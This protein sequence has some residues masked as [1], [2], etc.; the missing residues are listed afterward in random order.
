M[1]RAQPALRTRVIFAVLDLLSA[2][3]VL[4]TMKVLWSA[5]ALW[6]M[7]LG[8]WA[9]SLLASAIGLLT[10]TRTGRFF[11]RLAAVYQLGFLLVL[12]VGILSSVAYLSGI[13]GQVGVGVA[14]VLLLILALLLELMGLVPIFKLR[15]IGVLENDRPRLHRAWPF[16]ALALVVGVAF[17]CVSVHASAS[18]GPWVPISNDG[19]EA[20]ARYLSAI[21]IGEAGPSPTTNEG[22]PRD[23]WV[24]RAYRRGRLVSRIE[25]QGSLDEA[26]EALGEALT[27]GG[28]EAPSGRCSIA[29]DRIVAET[30]IEDRTGLL[31]ALSIVPGMDGVTGDIDGRRFAIAP[32]EL[33]LRRMLSEHVPIAFIPDF[34][35]GVDLDEARELLCA[36][37][38]RAEDCRVEALRRARTESWVH[39]HENTYELQRGRP[40][41]DA[42]PS[43][44]DARR[45][46][47]SAGTYVVRALQTDGRFRYKLFPESARSEMDPYSIAR[48]AGTTWFLLELYEATGSLSHLGSAQRALDWLEKQLVDCGDGL[49]CLRQG[50]RARLGTQALS[51]I[52]FST[53]SRVASSDRYA[54]TIDDLAEVILRLQRDDGDFDFALDCELGR[55]IAGDRAFYAAGQAAL[56][57]A[58][59]GQVD[60]DE[61]RLHGARAALDFMAG[62]YWDFFLSDLFFLEE[63]WTC[64]AADEVHR[65]YGDPDHAHL[66]LAVAGFNRQLQHHRGETVFE[67]YVGGVGFTPFFPPYTTSTATRADAMI[68]AY[69]ISKRQG[70][71]DPALRQGIIDAV[72]FLTHNQYGREDT[73][74]FRSGSLA[75]GGVPW[76]YYDP[77]I[78]I[79][80]VQHCG[81]V[82]LHGADVIADARTLDSGEE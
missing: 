14:V 51:L 54:N 9:A 81:A 43:A 42:T 78:R 44:E 32:Q 18:L 22:T 36:N 29:I 17:H 79:D 52:A 72:A 71:P 70:E 12:T 41:L 50:N 26:A 31:G 30:D 53:H 24:V 5:S 6:P 38:K 16:A 2:A 23:H 76:S 34:E 80:T 60:D 13:Y 55:T 46:A 48:H 77:V 3:A 67:D 15:S 49:R 58:L 35:I 33:V 56:A 69:R 73:Y 11:A 47:E 1:Q 75:V 7:A 64:L 19:R 74:A 57:L 20:M 62:P 10:G 28:G 21:V 68:A 45:A 61:R 27:S 8:V 82:M 65:L 37:A 63:H 4:G 25:A 40:A 39:H 59:S 66:C